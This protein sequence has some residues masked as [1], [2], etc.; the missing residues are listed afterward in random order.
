[1]GEIRDV[2]TLEYYDEQKHI[3]AIE[4]DSVIKYENEYALL[5]GSFAFPPT[6]MSLGELEQKMVILFIDKD[7]IEPF[8]HKKTENDL[9]I[10]FLASYPNKKVVASIW[11]TIYVTVGYDKDGNKL[12]EPKYLP[13][14]AN[15]DLYHKLKK[16]ATA[17]WNQNNLKDIAKSMREIITNGGYKDEEMLRNVIV[18][19][20]LSTERD[21]FTTQM[22]KLS[23]NIL[24][25]NKP[26]GSL[27]FNVYFDGGGKKMNKTI[28]E[29]TGNENYDLIPSGE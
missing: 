15:M 25:M 6:F 1:M 3:Q 13:N 9:F 23:A 22:R 2:Q 18:S 7:Y 11:K 24:G 21:N 28:I 4:Q 8:S 14:D 16:H 27:S 5:E 10:S 26:E 12:E 17:I 29:A 20:A 19:D